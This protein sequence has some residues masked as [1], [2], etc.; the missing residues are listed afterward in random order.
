[1]LRLTVFGG[2][3]LQRDGSRLEGA[4]AQPKR[5]ALLAV[6]AAS[7][8]KG[9]AREKLIALLWPEADDERARRNLAQAVYVAI[10]KLL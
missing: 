5:L 8:G 6:L 10:K 4:A 2:L 9:T 7:G 1:M 3:S